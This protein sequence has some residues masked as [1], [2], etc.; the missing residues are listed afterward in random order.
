MKRAI[1]TDEQPQYRYFPLP[2]G[3]ADV[4][5]YKFVETETVKPEESETD[6]TNYIYNMNEFRVSQ[7]DVTEE[8]VKSNPMSYLD[9]TPVEVL[10]L[11]EQIKVLTA[12][13]SALEET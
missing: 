9:Y 10:S 13:I 11:E 12:R 8:M 2:D 5:I 1:F 3:K 6:T 7:K 4:F